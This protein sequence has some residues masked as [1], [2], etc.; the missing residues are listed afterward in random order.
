MHQAVVAALAR[1]LQP[2]AVPPLARGARFQLGPQLLRIDINVV[3]D[4]APRLGAFQVLLLLVRRLAAARGRGRDLGLRLFLVILRQG[5]GQRPLNQVDHGSAEEH[6]DHDPRNQPQNRPPQTNPQ[7]SEVLPEGHAAL[8]KQ[9]FVVLSGHGRITL[10][11]PASRNRGAWFNAPFIVTSPA[12][13]NNDMH[14]PGLAHPCHCLR[15]SSAGKT[16]VPLLG[17]KQCRKDLVC[18]CVPLLACKQCREEPVYPVCHCLLASS[19]IG[20]LFAGR[21]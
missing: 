12:P 7:L 17:C 18:P 10:V 14:P 8:G 21:R 15:A 5:A 1:F 9:V 20:T 16:R 4:H 13:I 6:A 11:R 19:A 2:L 3:G